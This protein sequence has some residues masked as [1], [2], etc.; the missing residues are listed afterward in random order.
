[1]LGISQHVGRQSTSQKGFDPMKSNYKSHGPIT[2]VDGRIVLRRM[3]RKWGAMDW[4][5]LAQDRDRWQALV[6]AVMKLFVP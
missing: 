3:F 5:D 4:T 1:M 6:N 2:D